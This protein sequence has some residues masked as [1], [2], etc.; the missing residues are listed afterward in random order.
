MAGIFTN[1]QVVC[2]RNEAEMRKQGRGS[3]G[4]VGR[5]RDHHH[6]HHHH[7]HNCKRKAVASSKFGSW[8]HVLVAPAF[9]GARS[10]SSNQRNIANSSNNNNN[11]SSMNLGVL[12]LLCDSAFCV[13]DLWRIVCFLELLLVVIS[14]WCLVSCCQVLFVFTCLWRVSESGFGLFLLLSASLLFL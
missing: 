11:N 9:D 5:R 7:H 1:K 13:K 6:H 3:V 14:I 2:C 8:E 12:W 10:S 4:G